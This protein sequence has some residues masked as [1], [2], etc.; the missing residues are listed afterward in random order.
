MAEEKRAARRKKVE[1]KG[2]VASLKETMLFLRY[3]KGK[4]D[5]AL[6]LTGEFHKEGRNWLSQCVETG[7]ATFASTLE[8]ARLELIELITLDLECTEKSGFLAEELE[9]HNVRPLKIVPPPGASIP[10]GKG[11][12]TPKE[13]SKDLVA[14]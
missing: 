2:P 5:L 3:R 12:A 13:A 14:A 7:I 1:S 4:P 10:N 9:K 6:L 8:Q 11:W